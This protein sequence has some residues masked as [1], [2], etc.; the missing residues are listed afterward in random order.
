[1]FECSLSSVKE[2]NYTDR[3]VSMFEAE[4]VDNRTENNY[5][6]ISHYLTDHIKYKRFS[7]V[8]ARTSKNTKIKG[9]QY[10]IKILVVGNRSDDKYTDITSLIHM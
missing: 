8:Y 9:V 10:S 7:A 3:T 4:V 2:V 1:L 6:S 5:V